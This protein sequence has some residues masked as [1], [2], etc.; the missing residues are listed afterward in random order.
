[1]YHLFYADDAGSPG[2]DLTFFEYPGADRGRAGAG[3]VHRIIMRVG[4]AGALDFWAERLAGEGIATERKGDRLRFSDPEGIGLE[5]AVSDGRDSA[6]TA[7][8]DGIPDE[9]ALQGFDGV[10][11]YGTMPERSRQLMDAL[12]FTA[13]DGGGFELRGP[14]RGATYDI[15][16]TTEAGIPGAGTVHHVAFASTMEDHEAWRER[17][18][19]AARTPRR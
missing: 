8:R 14:D 11:V 12:G 9:M 4:S 6:L 5:L 19:R 2:A 18:Q 13:R 10:R 17:A 7:A 16:V 15:D 1:M 3:M